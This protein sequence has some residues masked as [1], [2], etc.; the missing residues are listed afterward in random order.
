MA[1]NNRIPGKFTVLG[2]FM[3]RLQINPSGCWDWTGGKSLG[4]GILNVGHRL[5][6]ERAHRVAYKL[7]WGAIPDGMEV[8]HHCDRKVCCA[9]THLFIGTHHENMLDAAAKG[10]MKGNGRTTHV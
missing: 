7:F 2:R 8:C 10:R 3:H 6:P 4:Y 1:R 5:V 9:P